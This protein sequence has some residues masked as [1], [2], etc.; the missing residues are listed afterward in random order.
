MMA[1]K[2]ANIEIKRMRQ[3]SKAGG[4]YNEKNKINERD[5]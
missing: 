4:K 3:L 2:K 5:D 1:K